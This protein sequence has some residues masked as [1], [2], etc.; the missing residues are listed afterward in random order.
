MHKPSDSDSP[1]A[2]AA[3]DR[4]S[5][6]YDAELARGLSLTGEE[7][8][9]YAR[10]RIAWLAR[11][12]G[13]W[14]LCPRH[15]LDFGCGIGDTA[16]LL[17]EAFGAQTV[18][19]VDPSSGLLETARRENGNASVSFVELGEFAPA[20]DIDLAYCNG[21]FHHVAPAQRPATVRLVRRALRPG[22]IF[23]L[24]E[25]NPWNPG[26]RLIMSRVPFDRDA[27]LLWPSET[28]RLLRAE[29]FEILATSYRF[30]FP[31]FLRALRPA[32]NWLA[33]WALGGQYQVLARQRD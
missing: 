19:G 23:A 17:L 20:G 15:I 11:C 7:R 31:S 22:G 30:I 8:D 5:G 1:R 13:Q 28:R 27:I 3:F 6:T 24:W 18:L 16:P 14:N 12:L 9:F 21:V 4:V 26:T 33:G 25:N 29:G 2:P 32:E 10:G